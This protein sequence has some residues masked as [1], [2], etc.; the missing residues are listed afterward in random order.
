M[1]QFSTD[2]CRPSELTGCATNPKD[3]IHLALVLYTDTEGRMRTDSNR[4]RSQQL[5]GL[6][7]GPRP[8]GGLP[9]LPRVRARWRELHDKTPAP[10]WLGAAYGE[11]PG[12]GTGNHNT[13]RSRRSVIHVT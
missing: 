8:E 13:G 6:P 5:E 9:E 2:K 10:G 7:Q 4:V 1:T 12:A 3:L 11:R